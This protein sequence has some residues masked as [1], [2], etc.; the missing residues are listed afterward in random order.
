MGRTDRR[1]LVHPNAPAD[2]WVTL[3]QDLLIL[4][5]RLHFLV[6]NNEGDYIITYLVEVLL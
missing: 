4:S 5:P 6:S 1:G 2:P 3:V